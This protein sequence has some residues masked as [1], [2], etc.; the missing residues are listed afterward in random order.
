MREKRLFIRVEL[1]QD[2]HQMHI[3]ITETEVINREKL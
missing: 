1:Q 2:T 3:C